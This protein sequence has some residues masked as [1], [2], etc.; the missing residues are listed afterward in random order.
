M[1]DYKRIANIINNYY[2]I[3]DDLDTPPPPPPN[4]TTANNSPPPASND[5]DLDTPPPPKTSTPPAHSGQ[6]YQSR[7]STNVEDMQTNLRKCIK[8]IEQYGSPVGKSSAQGPARSFHDFVINFYAQ[9]K[10]H[11]QNQEINGFDPDNKQ[12]VLRSLDNF[13][14]SLKYI[15]DPHNEVNLDGNWGPRTN[16]AL[17]N[18]WIYLNGMNNVTKDL[19]KKVPDI[20]AEVDVLEKNILKSTAVDMN[21]LQSELRKADGNAK[22][23]NDVMPNILKYL[24]DVQTA[25]FTD[26]QLS[27]YLDKDYAMFNPKAKDKY[28]VSSKDK[29]DVADKDAGDST[30]QINPFDTPVIDAKGNKIYKFDL[31]IFADRN[32]FDSYFTNTLGYNPQDNQKKIDV[33][34][35][36]YSSINDYVNRQEKENQEQTNTDQQSPQSNT[37][38][39]TPPQTQPGRW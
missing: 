31:K 24:D 32:S 36:I 5:D 16:N 8:W 17:K 29:Q 34:S 18:L 2:K 14:S 30:I 6:V 1:I 39:Q 21:P 7:H 19:G 22:N 13:E 26:Q 25:I 9:G 27:K 37:Q 20:S 12:N 15:G 10:R 38:T 4:Q 3:A 35:T 28:Y 11:E 23:V 33:L